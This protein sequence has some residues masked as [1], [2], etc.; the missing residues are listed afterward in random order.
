MARHVIG[1][2]YSAIGIENVGGESNIDNLTHA[3][4]AANVY[5][6]GHLTKKYRSIDY[7][8]GHYEY[9]KFSDNLLWLEQD[10]DY[11]TLKYDPG[12]RFMTALREH[13]PNLKPTQ[14]EKP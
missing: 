4:L 3:Q 8:I 10:K 2:N 9:K 13:F 6:I 1:L 5:L 14:Q 12:I 11:R 7:L